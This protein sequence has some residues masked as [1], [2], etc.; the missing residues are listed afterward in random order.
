MIQRAETLPLMLIV[1][2]SFGLNKIGDDEFIEQV[3]GQSVCV[4]F[5]LILAAPGPS[6]AVLFYKQALPSP[7]VKT[8]LH[9]PSVSVYHALTWQVIPWIPVLAILSA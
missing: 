2:V 4:H 5:F 6:E 1:I 9:H 8:P 7:F 3:A